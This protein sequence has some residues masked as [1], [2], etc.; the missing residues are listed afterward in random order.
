MSLSKRLTALTSLRFQWF[1]TVP[2]LFLIHST[3]NAGWGQM[4]YSRS[5]GPELLCVLRGSSSQVVVGWGVE[6]LLAE[7]RAWPRLTAREAR[8]CGLTM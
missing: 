5:Q 4:L 7:L 3:V 2:S 1:Y 6:A 8:K